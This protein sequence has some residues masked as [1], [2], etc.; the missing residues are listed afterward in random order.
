MNL[1]SFIAFSYY[2][3][4]DVNNGFVFQLEKL[5]VAVRE[6]CKHSSKWDRAGCLGRTETCWLHYSSELCFSAK[7]DQKLSIV[8]TRL[9]RQK[10]SLTLI[11]ITVCMVNKITHLFIYGRNWTARRRTMYRWKQ[12]ERQCL[13]GK[14]Q[15]GFDKVWRTSLIAQNSS[16]L[17]TATLTFAV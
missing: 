3:E 15:L 13:E 4:A 10:D 5:S 9:K 11:K 8:G 17:I 1:Y 7:E 16:L 2:F 6:V 12:R 14:C